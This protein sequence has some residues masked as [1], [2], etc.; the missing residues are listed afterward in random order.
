MS[1]ANQMEVMSSFM[2]EV[3][4]SGDF[5]NLS[6][7][8]SDTYEVIDDPGDAWNGMS[9]NHDEFITR[10]MHSRNAFS[11][12]RFDI[13]EMIDGDEKIAIRWYMSGTHSGDLPMIP[14][15]N[16]SFSI[17]GMT[18]YY[19][20]NG[21]ISGHRQAFDQLGFIQQIDAFG[22]LANA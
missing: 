18:F 4:N 16:K 13:Q 9:L 3:W 2:N 8:V 19:F 12:L 11:D 14:A 5:T 22:K 15:A 17:S 6:D 21:K 20:K 10:V 1:K 7:Y